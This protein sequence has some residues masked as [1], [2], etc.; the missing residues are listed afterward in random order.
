METSTAVVCLV[1]IVAVAYLVR[2]ALREKGDIEAS[3]RAGLGEFSLKA[4]ERK[5]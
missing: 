3:A 2:L 4:R 1:F 5:K